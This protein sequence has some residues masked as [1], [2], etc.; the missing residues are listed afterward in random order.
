MGAI[1]ATA[2]V[3]HQVSVIGAFSPMILA[4]LMGISWQ[5]LIGTP[6]WAKAGIK[7]CLR[8]ILR[9]GVALLGL[10]LT[11][12]QIIEV[13][14]RGVGII[15]ATMLSTFLF[16]TWL[17]ASL[18][19]DR[20]LAQLIAGGTSVCGA[21]AVIA[22]N[23]VTRASDEDVSY[24]IACVTVFGSVAMCLYPLL[25]AVLNLDAHAFGL[26]AG[27]SIH[28]IAQVVAAAFQDGQEAGKFGTIAKLSRVLMLAPM[29]LTLSFIA[30]RKARHLPDA[31]Q[32]RAEQPPLPWFVGGFIVLVIINSL[33][34]IP[35][36]ARP[37][38]A[39]TTTFLLSA[40]LAAMGMET[41]LR[42]LR[43]KGLRPAALAALSF[44]FIGTFSL[45][46]IKLYM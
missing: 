10:Q 43:A 27:A 28:E 45:I 46:L 24:A 21:S 23:S 19:V 7:F 36:H 37:Q 29:I 2:F 13:G 3:L 30:A 8:R 33:V 39:S 12:A 4:I 18:K 41:D 35:D 1:A 15:L 17:G 11:L 34:D 20:K 16:T 26:W 5:N 32:S 40:A 44:V 31:D 14:G 25:P 22:T 42:K 38:I 9:F 6:A